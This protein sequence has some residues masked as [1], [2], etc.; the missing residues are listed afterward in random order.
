MK[1]LNIL[2]SIH[3]NQNIALDNGAYP[4]ITET[5]SYYT[6]NRSQKS[7]NLPN[8]FSHVTDHVFGSGLR[9]ACIERDGTWRD[10][11]HNT[12]SNLICGFYGK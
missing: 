6:A 8:I 5:Y 10:I 3:N 7:S 1:S 4:L 11:P 12:K 2:N 9:G